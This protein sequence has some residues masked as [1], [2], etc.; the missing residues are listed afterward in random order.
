MTSVG[1]LYR[2]TVRKTCFTE[3]SK[4]CKDSVRG[5]AEDG[6]A[7]LGVEFKSLSDQKRLRFWL[8]HFLCTLCFLLFNNLVFTGA[9]PWQIENPAE[10]ICAPP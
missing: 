7:K 1:L 9:M 6:G 3:G 2:L 8:L 5:A 10:V 4:G